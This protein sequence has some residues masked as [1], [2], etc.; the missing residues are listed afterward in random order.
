MI[1]TQFLVQLIVEMAILVTRI[2]I[3]K[4]NNTNHAILFYLFYVFQMFIE[5]VPSHGGSLRVFLA[6]SSSKRVVS[7][8]VS[9]FLHEEKKK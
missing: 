6:K 3:I 1:L 7:S 9:D 8:E 2:V 5:N 4:L